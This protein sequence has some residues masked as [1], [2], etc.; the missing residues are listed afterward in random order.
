MSDMPKHFQRHFFG[1]NTASTEQLVMAQP[2]PA[3]DYAT[4]LH[5]RPAGAGT[6]PPFPKIYHA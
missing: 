4:H 3:L 6:Q 1:T 5:Q 2:R